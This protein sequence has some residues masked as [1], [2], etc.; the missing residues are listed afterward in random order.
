MRFYRI[1]INYLILLLPIFWSIKPAAAQTNILTLPQAIQL[2]LDTSYDAKIADNQIE[3]AKSDLQVAKNMRY[4]D[5][6][7]TLQSPN[8]SRNKHYS[9][10]HR[11]A[12]SRRQA[13]TH[14]FKISIQN[15][16]WKKRKN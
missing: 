1:K 12:R 2:A 16:R 11:T 4:P 10:T 7:I 14:Y 9:K 5:F 8:Y 3:I 13:P 15:Y 6:K